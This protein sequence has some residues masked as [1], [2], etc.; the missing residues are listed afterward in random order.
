MIKI[1]LIGLLLGSLS[2]SQVVK[3][4]GDSNYPPYS[5]IENGKAKGIYVDIIKLVFE[6]IPEYDLELNMTAWKRAISMTKSGKIVGFFPPYYSKKRTAW[7]NFSISILGETSSVFAKEN[8]LKGKK[9]F[10]E[11]FFGLTVCLNRGFTLM[12]GGEEF[13]N[14]IEKKQIKLI[15]ANNNKD[16]LSRL[17]RGLADF[18][19][20]DQFIDI[21]KF[22]LIKKGMKATLNFGH[23]GFTLKDE[24]YP[25][26]KDLTDK[27]NTIVKQMQA[28]GTIDK[29][30]KN[31]KFKKDI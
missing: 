22:P 28:D 29:I 19:I 4:F 30:I 14:A 16:C 24:K 6:K 25:F 20:N 15:E 9:R 27:F 11:D 10:P 13:K 26:I 23:I 2:A 1:I 7:T 18:Y 3:I 12:T 5:Y 31:Y 21:S 8:V 17:K